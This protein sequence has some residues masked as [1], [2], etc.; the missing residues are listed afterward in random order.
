MPLTKRD[1]PWK[2][3][4]GRREDASAD[5]M[6][7]KKHGFWAFVIGLVAVAGVGT[8]FATVEADEAADETADNVFL[9]ELDLAE[10]LEIW[11]NQY[12]RM[13]PGDDPFSQNVGTWPAA[14]EEFSPAWDAA[15]AERD[16]ATWL[17]PFSVERIGLATIIRD[18]N[19][20][21]LWN[22]TTDFAKDES[23][24]VTLTGALVD[25]SDW[26]LWEAAG[27]EIERRLSEGSG[28]RD[29][30]GGGDPS[31][32]VFGL[33][34]TNM[35]IDTNED[36]HFDFA[37]ESNGEVQVFCRAMHYV[38]WTN[39]GVVTT[40]DENEVVTNDVVHWDQVPGEKFRGI[41]DAWESLGVTT[42]TNG[43]GS[44]ADTNHANPLFDRVR[45]YAAAQYAD[46]DND[47]LT[48]GEEWLWGVSSQTDDSD[49]DGLPDYQEWSIYHTDPYNPDT[50]GDG[51][52]DGEEVNAQTD[53]LDRLSATRLA[54][55]VLV[56][57]VKYSGDETNQWVQLHCSGPRRVNVS[58][59][60]VQAAG[61]NWETVATLPDN[62]WMTPGHFLLIGDEGVTNADLTAELGLA[63]AYYNLPTAGVRFVAPEGATNEPIDTMFYG[64][65][66][67]FNAHG[68]ET[69][70]WSSQTTNL[71]AAPAWHLERWRLGL[72]RD[73]ED[74][75]R[76]VEDGRVYNSDDILDSDGDDLI[77][78]IEY[79]EGLDP[80]DPDT[81]NDNLLDGF[82]MAEGL[83]PALPDTD[84]DGTPDCDETDPDTQQPYSS[85][86]QANGLTV[87]TVGP[88][89][90]TPGGDLGL[91]GV[92]TYTLTD[93]DGFAVWGTIL[94][95]G[96]TNENYEVEV[97]N[98][99]CY[100][101][102]EIHP[103]PNHTYVKVFAAPNGTN[104]IRIVVTDN[105]S[106]AGVI[107]PDEQGADINAAFR[108]LRL[109]AKVGGVS[110]EDEEAPGVFLPNRIVH[111][112]A[113]RTS[114][115]LSVPDLPITT[116]FALPRM[117][118][119]H[120]D[121]NVVRVFPEDC[122]VDG[123][124]LSAV[125]VPLQMFLG[126]NLWLEG[127]VT[128]NIFMDW[129]W[130]D[131]E[132]GQ[133]RVK[134]T[135]YEVRFQTYP[136]TEP[137]PDKAHKLNINTRKNE[138]THY[139]PF[140]NCVSHVNAGNALDLTLYLE[141]HEDADLRNEFR[142]VLKW[143]VG[144]TKTGG[145]WISGYELLLEDS[146]SLG[147]Q[148]SR[149]VTVA[150]ADQKPIDFLVVSLIPQA[151][152]TDFQQWY[153]QWTTNTAWLASL[154]APYISVQIA[155]SNALDPEGVNCNF[156]E[157]P[158]DLDN[159][160]HPAGYYEMRSKSVTGGHGHQAVYSETGDIILSGPSAGSADWATPDWLYTD[161]LHAAH[162]VRPY[163]FAAQLDGNPIQANNYYIP[164]NLTGPMMH[165]GVYLN[166]YLECRPPVPN[167]RQMLQHGDCP[168]N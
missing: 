153:D 99:Y 57:A 136:G 115:R 108:V 141:G 13:T 106:G 120:W 148:T 21:V 7:D 44:F 87:E 144:T 138:R 20:T 63:G 91:G 12:R 23:A 11:R 69:N 39:F 62:T 60:R 143:K 167:D 150:F 155:N 145:G 10:R 66:N 163:I 147:S 37:W 166:R 6:M 30:E 140:S 114:C 110:E 75:W 9:G 33:R 119:L 72:D 88:A 149:Y 43:G 34:F 40:N 4:A 59:F 124:P 158:T 156:W 85:K 89:N 161:A 79:Q 152:V 35:W 38:C 17:V 104:E 53:P 134:E 129:Q 107:D 36:C 132:H 102:W 101:C 29:G 142:N 71:W 157:N 49:N 97:Q 42:V 32:G 86:Q 135:V 154:P 50:D 122:P 162:D 128:T 90:W 1:V 133:D 127:V 19:G 125:T 78:E 139:F 45:F 112:N 74:D 118:S 81:D 137:G 25:E 98:A 52:T 160:Y 82:E 15:P 8:A 46:T 77:D 159:F 84:G 146:L 94:E 117:L 58:G 105:S 55:G 51:W 3:A 103:T 109:N 22:G 93:V 61:T 126:T 80:L 131:Q 5:R 121:P 111:T 27:D 130:D 123:T 151:T 168:P 18:A 165:F 96:F 116:E 47:G 83:S 68:L 54:K 76:Y 56:H 31:N 24:D 70:G 100:E 16:L 65:N 164:T 26:A 64:R 14:W 28:L 48:D 95:G 2:V 92:V 73:L 67:T 41:P 113:P